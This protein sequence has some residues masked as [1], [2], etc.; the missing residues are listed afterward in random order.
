MKIRK[1]LG[2]LAL[3]V[4][5]ALLATPAKAQLEISFRTEKNDSIEFAREL[6]RHHPGGWNFDLIGMDI[7]AGKK[8]ESRIQTGGC[9]FQIPSIV[10]FS[11]WGFGFN[12]ALGT[13]GE[14][15]KVDV[16]MGRSFHFC[17]EDVLA[18]RFSPWQHGAFS[19][20]MGIDLKNYRMTNDQ[21]FVM[22]Y[23]YKVTSIEGYPAGVV[24]GSSKIRTFSATYNLKYIQNLGRGFR[25]AFGP[26]L[27]V[28]RKPG[29][30]HDIRTTYSD[31]QG[32]HEERFK[33]IRTNK[34]GI[35]LVGMVNYKNCIGFYAKYGL[36]NV[37]ENNYGPQFK[38]LS[39]GVMVLGL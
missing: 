24:P 12:D 36:S 26:E 4:V 5:M 25:L 38:S 6:S 31:D 7:H 35:N 13:A 11:G 2:K 22:N 10:F 18:F 20:G 3:C 17:I 16:N 27:S 32:E 21:R 28:V 29:K 34:V 33:G 15:Q 19:V 1:E 23:P 9:S 14:G 39:V 8:E 30:N 37:M